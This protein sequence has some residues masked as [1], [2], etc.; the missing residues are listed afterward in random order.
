MILKGVP[1]GAVMNAV[2]DELGKLTANGNIT[3]AQQTMLQGL[4]NDIHTQA[5]TFFQ[6]YLQQST[7]GNQQTGL[8]LPGDFD[9]LFVSPSG[10]TAVRANLAAKFLTYLQNQLV[11]QTIVQ[12]LTAQLNADASLTKKLL[13]NTAVLFHPT[14][15]ATPPPPTLAAL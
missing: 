15:T 11:S 5:L 9:T 13:T 2:T 4:L 8:L 10:T 12:S 7:V 6:G 14:Q 3:A 1:T